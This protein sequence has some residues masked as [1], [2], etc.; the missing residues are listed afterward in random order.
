M[1]TKDKKYKSSFTDYLRV[2]KLA[3][4]RKQE[5]MLKY[6]EYQFAKLSENQQL[7][8]KLMDELHLLTYKID[9]LQAKM[10]FDASKAGANNPSYI[11]QN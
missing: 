1:T 11:I 7:I 3:L 9:I 10:K 2:E 6:Q 5:F 4:K 8:D